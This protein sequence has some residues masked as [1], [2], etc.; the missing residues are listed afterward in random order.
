MWIL[1]LLCDAVIIIEAFRL[2]AWEHLIN[3]H[4][5]A[6]GSIVAEV[7]CLFYMNQLTKHDIDL[8]PF[9]EKEKVRVIAASGVD[10]ERVAKALYQRKIDVQAGETESLALMQKP[11]CS[12]YHFCTADGSAV[13]AAYV[14]GMSGRVVSLEDCLGKKVKL[15]H[16]CTKKWMA[17]IK[18]DAIRTFGIP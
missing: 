1:R 15:P 6:I 9:I 18:A 11:E 4:E 7:E 5:I 14:L 8:K 10:L 17:G 13:K 16:K 12:D 3:D 2:N